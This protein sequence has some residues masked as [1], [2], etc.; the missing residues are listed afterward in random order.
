MAVVETMVNGLELEKVLPKVTVLFERDNKFYTKIKKRDVEV[1]SNRLMRIPLEIR[2]GGNFGYY[3]PDG[4]DL[5]RGG[6]PTWDKATLNSVFVKEGIE[7][8][9]LVD[10]STNSNR[11]AVEQGVKRLIA[12]ALDELRRQLDA[13]LMQDGSGQIGTVTTDS[14]SNPA[15][16]EVT[17][18]SDGFGVRLMRYG[19]DVQIFDANN[20][21]RGTSTITFWD[22]ENCTIQLTPPVASIA[23]TDKIVATGISSPA[24]FAAL[25]GVAYHDNN[26]S[27]GNW[28]NMPRSTNPEVRASGVN[29]NSNMLTLPLPRLAVNKI[30]NRVGIDNDFKL[31]AWTHPCQKQSYEEIGQLVSFIQKQA[32]DEKL[33]MYFDGMQMAGAPVEDSY[34]WNMKRI[35]F[36][37][38][39]IWGRAETLPIG[40]YTSDNRNIFEIR[41]ASGGVAA[42]D[43]F[44]MTVGM[45]TFITNPA[46]A[47]Y[48]YGLAVP[49]GYLG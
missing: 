44:Y 31:T 9:K 19:Q 27:S 14:Q 22:V 42:A 41:G 10:W 4:G 5:G 11:K 48:I 34:N 47:S 8:T 7:Y 43:I 32:K 2:P 15:Y 46:A 18:T 26:S 33:N 28:L 40:F 25:Y 3:N 20:V 38:E 17:C 6:G 16:D 49:S 13:Q 36:I 30:G 35:D 21:Y 12:T 24:A 29:A 39:S 45:Q 37:P 23:P 1:I